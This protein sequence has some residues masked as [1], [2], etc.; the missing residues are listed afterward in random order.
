MEHRKIN[1]I[2]QDYSPAQP[3]FDRPPSK[4]KF[5]IIGLV[6]LFLFGG[7]MAYGFMPAEFP[8][9]PLSYDPVTLEAEQP[10]GFF[11]RIKHFI[12]KPEKKLE[13]EKKDRVNILL[14]G[15]GGPG[16]DGPYLTD[17]IMIASLKPSSKEIALISIPRD[18][19]VEI[20]NQGI[21]KI[22]HANHFGEVMKKDFGPLLTSEV[23]HDTLGIPI[24]YYVRVDFT[25]FKE[26]VDDV[27]GVKV[28]V[29]RGFTD[30]E[31]PAPN[32]Q[33]QTVSFKAG[34]QTMDGETAL[35]YARSRHG[36]NGEGS[37]FA[38]AKRQ[39]KVIL[40]LKE[41]LISFRTLTNPVKINNI[42]ETLGQHLLTNME[43]SDIIS[44]AKIG[45]DLDT[46]NIPTLVLDNSPNGFLESGY[47]ATGAFILTPKTGNFDDIS[48]A[49]ENIF[50]EEFQ[51]TSQVIEVSNNTPTQDKPEL[52]TAKVE[53][54]NGTWRA[55]LAARVRKDLL[56]EGFEVHTI[57]NTQ[58]RPL[59]K[60]G[61]YDMTNG[62]F[63]SELEDVSHT[64][65]LPIKET[66]P[67]TESVDPQT[68]IFIILGEDYQE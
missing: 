22:N 39:Q 55:G 41:K 8:N 32:E 19:A 5:W 67:S 4:K 24:H 59:M 16:H 44:F 36:N 61:I 53:I 54:L 17:T 35:T 47:S 21:R 46:T 2:E 62:Q 20:P 13:G 14:L 3:P 49:I 15:Q 1:F 66:P 40:A 25:A 64:L 30:Y 52:P 27:G 12:F 58:E 28:N 11:Q 43:F 26:L 37:D 56:D 65:N 45:K 38:R 18:L 50:D 9:D 10:N 63:S 7:C 29:D 34:V 31:Y 6:F 51:I 48:Q 42:L 68:S 33:Y 57:G 60:S 23:I